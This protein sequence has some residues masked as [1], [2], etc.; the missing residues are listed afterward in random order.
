MRPRNDAARNAMHTRVHNPP[1][2]R[3]LS[4][5]IEDLEAR[6]KDIESFEK[7]GGVM[8]EVDKVTV[9]LKK[10]PA[11]SHHR[12]VSFLRTCKVYED[13]KAQPTADMIF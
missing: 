6:E 9:A 8:T 4:N 10:V 1:R 13:L 11:T 5:V 7:C 2:P 12:S 3:D